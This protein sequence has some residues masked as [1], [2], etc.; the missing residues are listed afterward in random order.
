MS[1]S[2]PWKEKTTSMHMQQGTPIRKKDW[3]KFEAAWHR[4]LKEFDPGPGDKRHLVMTN[5]RTSGDQV[6]GLPYRL[7][8]MVT[9]GLA[10]YLP[11]HMLIMRESVETRETSDGG[12]YRRRIWVG[13]RKDGLIEMGVRS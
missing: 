10:S 8:N 1:T 6:S 12:M 3:R 11:E 9:L 4:A 2:C 5:T 7:Q 13:L